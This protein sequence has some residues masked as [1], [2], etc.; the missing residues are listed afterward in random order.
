MAY[1]VIGNMVTLPKK[2]GERKL[3]NKKVDL[4]QHI[5]YVRGEVIEDTELSPKIVKRFESGDEVLTKQIEKVERN[6]EKSE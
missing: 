6:S 1:K 5:V 3:G 2:V 4:N